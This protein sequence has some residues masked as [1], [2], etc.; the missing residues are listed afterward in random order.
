MWGR[1][2]LH[3]CWILNIF[4]YIVTTIILYSNQIS[5]SKSNKL[6]KNS[7]NKKI[8]SW[9]LESTN[10]TTYLFFWFLTLYSVSKLI[11][12]DPFRIFSVLSARIRNFQLSV[13]G[14]T[15]KLDSFRMFDPTLSQTKQLPPKVSKCQSLPQLLWNN[16]F[17]F[18]D[19]IF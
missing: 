13:E 3:Y 17:S 6:V 5:I 19:K 12:Q 1:F 15:Y 9:N 2:D 4:Y 14:I 18:N 8:A 7:N 10:M 16:K 11:L